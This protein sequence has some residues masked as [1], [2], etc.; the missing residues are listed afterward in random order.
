M[1]QSG[2]PWYPK[3]PSETY[4]VSASWR[5]WVCWWNTEP[6][7]SQW[8]LTFQLNILLQIFNL[9]L[10]LVLCNQRDIWKIN[11]LFPS[12][13]LILSV[14]GN[15]IG[16]V[17]LC[18]SQSWVISSWLPYYIDFWWDLCELF[19]SFLSRFLSALLTAVLTHHLAWVPTVMPSSLPPIKPACQKPA[20][21][22]V[23]LLAKSHP[24]NPLWAQL[25][26]NS[27]KT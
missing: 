12:P 26:K 1:S 23:D 25:G 11:Y 17:C 2:F 7:A 4:C 14:S 13:S 6:R 3:V 20:S 15:T 21:Q 5:R 9:V 8:S 18:G 22:T 10:L 27:H 24:Y 19:L 16:K